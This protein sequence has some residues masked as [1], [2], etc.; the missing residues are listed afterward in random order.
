M[1]R[2]FAPMIA[3]AAC[4]SPPL[5]INLEIADG[6][7]RTCPQTSCSAITLSCTPWVSIRVLD[8]H[9]PNQPYISVCQEVPLNGKSD[10]CSLKSVQL[11]SGKSVPDITLEVQVVVYP[12]SQLSTDPKTGDVVCPTDIQFDDA[13]GAPVEGIVSPGMPTGRPAIG[14]HAYFHAGDS[15]TT[16]WLGCTDLTLIDKSTCGGNPRIPIQAT[17][18]DFTTRL[19]VTPGDATTLTVSVGEPQPVVEMNQTVYKFDPMKV[20]RLDL[21]AGSDPPAWGGNV[22]LAFD[23]YVCLQVVDDGPLTTTGVTCVAAPPDAGPGM[24]IALVGELLRTTPLGKYLTALG[25]SF[26]SKGLVVG[27]VVD[28]TG[29]PVAGMTVS[30]PAGVH[31]R[32][33]DQAETGTTTTSTSSNGIFFSTDAPFGTLFQSTANPTNVTPAVVGGLIENRVTIVVLQFPL[34]VGS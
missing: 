3:L 2:R 6:P 17:V 9:A 28:D 27:I 20:E 25:Q 30:V 22:D 19:S 24:P 10:L 34:P 16:V 15:E 29:N 1:T 12:L 33:L 8:P 7:A 13:T 26:P 14:G 32:Y 5:T 21:V 23:N 11:P 18:D 4:G 31:I